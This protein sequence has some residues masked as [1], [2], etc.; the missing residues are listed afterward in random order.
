MR[1]EIWINLFGLPRRVVGLSALQGAL[2][3]DCVPQGVVSP[4]VSS[5]NYVYNSDIAGGFRKGSSDQITFIITTSTME[6]TERNSAVRRNADD[7]TTI[8]QG[9]IF[10]KVAD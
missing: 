1:T 8:N 4:G 5:R 2:S 10:L 3:V 7:Q 9:A 6:T